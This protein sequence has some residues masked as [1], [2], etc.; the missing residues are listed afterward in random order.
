MASRPIVILMTFTH[1]LQKVVVGL[2]LP[3]A[4]S[5]VDDELNATNFKSKQAQMRYCQLHAQRAASDISAHRVQ[6]QTEFTN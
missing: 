2:L 1:I 3:N 6:H 5:A 4:C